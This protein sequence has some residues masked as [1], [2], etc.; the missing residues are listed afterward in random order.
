MTTTTVIDAA[1]AA[2]Q[3]Q[4]LWRYWRG[5]LHGSEFAWAVAFLVPYIGVFFAFVVY[6]VLYGLWMGS[7]P[8]LYTELFSDPI[9]LN[10]VINTLVFLAVG[11]NIKLFLALMMS[12]FFMRKG[13]WTKALLMV[14]VLPWAVPAL[15]AFISI[16]WMLNGEWGLLNNA[17]WEFFGVEGP[18]YLNSHWSALFSAIYAHVWK[19]MPFWT[20]ILLAGRMSIPSEVYDAAQVDGATGIRRFLYVTFPLLANLYLVLTLLA[21]IFLLGDFNSVTFISGGGP[22]NSTHL[23]ATLGIDRA[24]GMGRPD[25]GVAIVMTALP[26]LIP[27]VIILMRR[28]KVAEV[29]L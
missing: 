3:R 19:W 21:T 16:H 27:L 2:G 1:S 17:L 8:H 9:Y 10:T 7:S 11:V 5:G 23:L 6:P 24:Y 25:L 13:W 29:Q 22:A 28:L 18:S 15:P 20:V 26:L 4:S 14:F 12:G